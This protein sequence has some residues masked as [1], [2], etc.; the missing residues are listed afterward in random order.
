MKGYIKLRKKALDDLNSK[1]SSKL[2]YHSVDHTLDA[3][4][5][6]ELYLKHL[7]I[8]KYQA[9]LLRIGILL[10]DIGF[11]A[12]IVEHEAK[13]AEIAT[14]MMS[15]LGFSKED[16]Q[17]VVG[18]ILSTKVPQQPHTVL[19]QIIC[20]VDLDYLGRDDFYPIGNLLFKELKAYSLVTDLNDWNKLQIKFLEN[21]KYH[22]DFAKKNRQPEK[23]KRIAELKK[24]INPNSSYS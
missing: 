15:D 14:E 7:N 19:E 21:H 11:T 1:L 24:L 2:S 8:D 3:L 10:H 23:E 12:T 17:I 18:L 16:I 22:T 6:C 5:T 9:K 20:D 4:Q 13:G